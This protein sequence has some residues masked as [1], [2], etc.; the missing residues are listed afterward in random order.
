VK[1]RLAR[2][3]RLQLGVLGAAV[4]ACLLAVA[5]WAA[6]QQE[7]RFPPNIKATAAAFAALV[8]VLSGSLV[9]LLGVRIGQQARID[10][11]LQTSFRFWTP[12]GGPRVGDMREPRRLGV[13]QAA[14]PLGLLS[15]DQEE[16][17]YVRRTQDDSLE[18]ALRLYSFVL[19]VGD[20]TAGKS[21]SAYE[22]MRR[23]FAERLLLVPGA[24]GSLA[25]IDEM[26]VR[27]PNCV[28]WLDELD[29]YLGSDGL[30]VALLER[31]TSSRHGA[32]TLLA[33]MRAAVWH[34]YT[35][36]SEIRKEE[37][38]VLMLA[39]RV[40]LER[41]FDSAEIDRARRLSHDPRIAAALPRLVSYGLAEYLAAGPPLLERYRLAR[42]EVEPCGAAIVRAAVDWQRT[43]LRRA[44]PRPVLERLYSHYLSAPQTRHLDRDAFAAGLAWACEPIH[45]RTTPALLIE[46]AEGSYQAFDYLVDHFEQHSDGYLVPLSTWLA[47]S[48][49]LTEPDDLAAVGVAAYNIGLRDVSEL[50]WRRAARAGGI[51]GTYNLSVLLEEQGKMDEAQTLRR[52]VAEGRDR[53]QQVLES[54]GAKNVGALPE[55]LAPLMEKG[56]LEDAHIEATFEYLPER[57]G[58]AGASTMLVCRVSTDCV[59][60]QEEWL[61]GLVTKR[62]H[63]DRLRQSG[64]PLDEIQ[65]L[66]SDPFGAQLSVDEI[67]GKY[68]LSVSYRDGDAVFMQA[69]LERLRDTAGIWRPRAPEDEFP[70]VVLRAALPPLTDKLSRRIK[71]SY[72]NLAPRDQGFWYW[73]ASSPTY[74]STITIHAREL[75]RDRDCTL[76]KALPSSVE[77]EQG[78]DGTWSISV[79]SWVLAG[80]GV[81]FFWARRQSG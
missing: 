67:I 74:V 63:R 76:T 48:A 44:A 27:L 36:E 14:I 30:S 10:R 22:A 18:E 1:V 26:D 23:L 70:L 81:S 46:V 6:I 72:R 59:A 15:A 11:R 29:R 25:V 40:A 37:R 45:G 69:P 50:V 49:L 9:S 32:V 53:L 78:E 38:A 5:V 64:V 57:A 28:L 47:L 56:G 39:E 33:T 8:S 62:T 35:T 16:P 79:D 80:H 60:R 71:L 75:A 21:R 55:L 61:C 20:S 68:D 66:E 43:G 24:K 51:G 58:T 73:I 65:V 31:L 13:H 52:W 12:R 7:P 54:G 4:L 19:L 41:R 3:Q 42:G 17:T 77:L 2:R 34:D